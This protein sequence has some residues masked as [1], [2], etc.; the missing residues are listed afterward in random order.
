MTGLKEYIGAN[1]E[2]VQDYATSGHSH[3]TSN[4]SMSGVEFAD[5]GLQ[6]EF[7]DAIGAEALSSDEESDEETE[8]DPKTTGHYF[9]CYLTRIKGLK[10]LYKFMCWS[11]YLHYPI[12]NTFIA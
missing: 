5:A 1:P 6:D 11:I 12:S 3:H 10:A 8:L 7:Y 4:V 9:S 2:L